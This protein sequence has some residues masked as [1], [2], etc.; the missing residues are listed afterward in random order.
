METEISSSA[1]IRESHQYLATTKILK[2]LAVAQMA[3]EAA[4]PAVDRSKRGRRPK[5]SLIP[6]IRGDATNWRKLKRDPMRP[7]KSTELNCSG[8]PR[9]DPNALT[10][11]SRAWYSPA[12]GSF[13]LCNAFP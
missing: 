13:F 10:L 6:P 8:D 7:P 5:R 1:S 11:A 2:E 3:Y 9:Y 12:L 4:T